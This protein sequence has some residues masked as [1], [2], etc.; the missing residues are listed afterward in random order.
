M[1]AKVRAR[2]PDKQHELLDFA[3]FLQGPRIAAAVGGTP[4]E[5][6]KDPYGL[7][8]EFDIDISEEDLAELRRERW[9]GFPRVD[10]A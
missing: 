3:Y 6:R 7:W 2:P 9:G 1:L 4:K 10:I 8:A 5:P